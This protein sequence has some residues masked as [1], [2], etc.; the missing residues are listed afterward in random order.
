MARR[1]ELLATGIPALTAQNMVGA[2]TSGVTA[3]GTNQATAYQMITPGVEITS[4]AGSTGVTL[5]SG[6]VGDWQ[7]VYN[8][9]SGN[10]ITIYPNGTD[11]VNNAATSIT[12]AVNKGMLFF[13][14][15]STAWFSVLTA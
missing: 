3:L 8:G 1:Q 13:K 6:D 11:T 15:S 9:N 2:V 12:L 10:T 5:M 7:W 14:R 4:A